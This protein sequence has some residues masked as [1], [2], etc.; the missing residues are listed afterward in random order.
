MPNIKLNIKLNQFVR[1]GD[2]R[3]S[4]DEICKTFFAGRRESEVIIQ[5]HADVLAANVNEETAE[6]SEVVELIDYNFNDS[7]DDM[8][9]DL[10]QKYVKSLQQRNDAIYAIALECFTELCSG[11]PEAV[12][13]QRL[14]AAIAAREKNKH[15]G[16][17][18]G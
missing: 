4:V 2:Y 7:Y 15:V 3:F 9:E 18:P 10:S 8:I 17:T 6:L 11:L 1:S 16:K 12:V 13:K 5:H 14:D